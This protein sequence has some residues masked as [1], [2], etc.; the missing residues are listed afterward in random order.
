MYFATRPTVR[1]L[2]A[3]LLLLGG[4]LGARPSSAACFNTGGD[5]ARVEFTPPASLT[6]PFGA[7]IGSVIYR[8]PTT[9]PL[10]TTQLL[11]SPNTSHGLQNAVGDSPAAGSVIFPTAVAG[12]GYRL[13]LS[14][15]NASVGPYPCCRT[16]GAWS[17]VNVTASA[18]LELVKT[19][20]IAN[21]AVLT[22]GPLAHW[23]FD[24]ELR[25]E[26]FSLGNAI[27]LVAPACAVNTKDIAVT[28]PP[29]SNTAFQGV[30]SAPGDTPFAILLQCTGGTTLAITLDTNLPQGSTAGVIAPPPQTGAAANIG[31]QIL[32]QSLTPVNFG[33]LKTVGTTPDGL[34]SLPY[35]ARYFQTDTPA[36]TGVVTASATFTLS[37]P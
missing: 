26:Q 19:G 13:R 17:F 1:F 23:L 32:D 5:I 10:T 12:V 3:M 25:A 31:V 34:L 36:G 4:A 8:S 21:G 30:G 11:C 22:A 6:V 37:Y 35:H 7:P 9:A 33:T 15:P 20:P 18:N 29:L 28:L 2:V 24:D 27:T 16:R 14:G